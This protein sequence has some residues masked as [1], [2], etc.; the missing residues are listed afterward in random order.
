MSEQE[1]TIRHPGF[2]GLRVVPFEPNLKVQQGRREVAESI[3]QPHEDYPRYVEPSFEILG[4]SRLDDFP[5]PDQLQDLH[6]AIFQGEKDWQ[7]RR[8]NVLV[9]MHVPPR[10]E[11]VSDLMDELA[12]VYSG[13]ELSLDNLYRW[14]VDFET[15]HPFE[16]GNGRV[17]GV[18][19]AL[20]SAAALGEDPRRRQRWYAPFRI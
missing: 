14:Y 13:R 19:V 4:N 15:I 12:H 8:C 10:W 3:N 18:A 7:F 20:L 9:G 16:D 1:T 5:T 6:C 11:L 17:G 2:G